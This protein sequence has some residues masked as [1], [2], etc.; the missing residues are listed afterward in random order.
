MTIDPAQVLGFDDTVDR[1]KREIVLKAQE[2]VASGEFS[3][4]FAFRL[5]SVTKALERIADHCTNICEQVIYL[6]TGQIVRHLPAG[7]TSPTLPDIKK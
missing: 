4:G 6:E 3:A 5:H 2:K 1:F 7:W